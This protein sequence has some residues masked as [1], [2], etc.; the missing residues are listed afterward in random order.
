GHIEIT[1]D[2]YPAD[3]HYLA[4]DRPLDIPAAFHGKIDDDRARTHRGK[5]LPRDQ[6]GG[7]ATWDEGGG[8]DDVLLLDVLGNEGGLLG[9][10]LP[11][12]FLGITAGGLG[13]AELLVLD[14]DE[15][16]A[17]AFDLLLCR[18]A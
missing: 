7:G 17:E 6:A 14:G 18:R 11:G 8:D 2:A 5:H 3:L 15:L 9:L 1:D 16:G 13:L 4:G 12:H 10:V